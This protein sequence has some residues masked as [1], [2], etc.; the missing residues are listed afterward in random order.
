MSV[1]LLRSMGGNASDCCHLGAWEGLTDGV[2]KMTCC[3]GKEGQ[4]PVIPLIFDLR[5][6]LPRDTTGKIAE[7]R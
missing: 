5:R 3:A 6:I 1:D 7:I 4:L 2:S